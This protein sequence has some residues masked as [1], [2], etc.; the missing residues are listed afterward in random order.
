MVDGSRDRNTVT[1]FRDS[2]KSLKSGA[3]DEIQKR[4]KDLAILQINDEKHLFRKH[5]LSTRLFKRYEFAPW[6][7]ADRMRLIAKAGLYDAWIARGLESRTGTERRI[8]LERRTEGNNRSL[9]DRR[10]VE[11]PNSDIRRKEERRS[12]ALP[13][14]RSSERRKG[15]LSSPLELKLTAIRQSAAKKGDWKQYYGKP[16]L[17]NSHAELLLG[18]FERAYSL[19]REMGM[20]TDPKSMQKLPVD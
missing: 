9:D 11:R 16:E 17:S 20:K 4:G 2:I 1:G 18:I 13:Y 6:E 15:I 7:V 5:K 14:R 3:I 8:S 10:E 19:G 12:T